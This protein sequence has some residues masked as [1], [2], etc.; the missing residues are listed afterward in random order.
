MAFIAVRCPHCQREQIVKRGKTDRDTQPYQCQNPT[1]VKG[2]FLLDYCNRGCLPAE[3][4][5]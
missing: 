1:C 5:A 3:A 2:S 4:R